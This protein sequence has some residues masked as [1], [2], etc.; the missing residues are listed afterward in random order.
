MRHVE[1]LQQD[2]VEE[3]HVGADGKVLHRF[4]HGQLARLQDVEPVDGV[5]LHHTD[6]DGPG[7]L[8]DVRADGDA[9]VVVDELRVVDPQEGW[10]VI[11]D[12]AGG[13]DG[14]GQA[15]AAYLVRAGDGPKT[16][17]AEPALDR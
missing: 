2:G 3:Q 6:G 10:L 15:A 17:I 14:A 16:K 8:Q 7:T 12:H 9:V 4:P 1:R 11:E 13:H 5:R